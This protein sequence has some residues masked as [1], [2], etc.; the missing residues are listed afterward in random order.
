MKRSRSEKRCPPRIHTAVRAGSI[1]GNSGS[2]IPRLASA[3]AAARSGIRP[4]SPGTLLSR[5]RFAAISRAA[6]NAAIESEVSRKDRS[7]D[8]SR[9]IQDEARRTG[10]RP[11][12]AISSAARRLSTA[13]ERRVSDARRRPY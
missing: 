11:A 8:A 1:R 2:T 9:W 5:T 7:R 6:M 10:T 4:A 12:S 13:V 3:P